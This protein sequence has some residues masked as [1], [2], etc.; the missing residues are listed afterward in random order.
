MQAKPSLPKSY[1]IINF[2]HPIPA[3]D[4]SIIR[5][6]PDLS[7]FQILDI[8]VRLHL[9]K[10]LAP[11]TESLVDAAIAFANGNIRNIDYL[12]LPGYDGAAVLIVNEFQARGYMPDIIRW[13]KV[14]QWPT[15][16]I[17]ATHHTKL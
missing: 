8:P 3:D 10:P 14:R 13:K 4:T 5:L 7:N 2:S 17:A 16:R 11:Q 12:R 9:N 6:I 1:L 15:V